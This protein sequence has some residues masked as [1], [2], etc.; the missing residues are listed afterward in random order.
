MEKIVAEHSLWYIPLCL[1]A[2]VLYAA[3]LYFRETKNEYP[4]QLRWGLAV[5]RA[6]AVSAIAFLLLNPLFRSVKKHSEN[7]VVL[8]L[9]DNSSSIVSGRD[10]TFYKAS[11]PEL[12]KEF[13]NQIGT[14]FDVESFT[15]SDELSSNIAEWDYSGQ[16]TNMGKALDAIY[17]RYAHRNVGA[18]V[19]LSDGINNRGVN[20]LYAGHEFNFPLYTVA[21]GDTALQTDL[22]VTRVDF[23]R[24]A[25]LENMFPVEISILGKKAEGKMAEVSIERNGRV[26][27]QTEI[28]FNSV[29]D[30][31][32]VQASLKASQTGM[33]KYTVRISSLDGEVSL[34]NNAYDFYIDVL[35]DKQKILLLANAP[36]PDVSAIK[37]AVGENINYTLDDFLIADFNGATDGYNLVILHGLPSAKNNITTIL[38]NLEQENMPC[39]FILTQRTYLPILNEQGT[40][41][42]FSGSNLLYNEAL[43]AV[44]KTFNLFGLSEK[45]EDAFDFLPPL[46]SPYGKIEMLPSATPLL[47]QQIG[48][49]RTEHPLWVFNQA[50]ER[51]NAVVLGPGLWKWRIKEYSMRGTHEAF[52]E[53]VNKT[54]QYLALRVDK[55]QFRVYGQTH[56]TE[57]DDIEF[58]AELYN[59]V[60]ELV[61]DPEVDITIEGS[62]GTKYPYSFS[63]TSNA[64]YLNAGNLSADTYTYAAHTEYGGDALTEKGEF[65]VSA[66]RLEQLSTEADHNLMLNL[67]GKYGG[68]MVYPDNLQTLAGVITD[69]EDIKTITYSQKRFSELLSLKWVLALILALLSVEWFVR[70]RAGGY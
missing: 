27:Y 9:Q 33:Q 29:K 24:I 52:N 60:F 47:L 28:S 34:V 25:Y 54:I 65:T 4:H 17:D 37:Q 8:V 12:V 31:K 50:L 26:L 21:L 7:P 69:R 67:A 20:P 32:T 68:E 49:V 3:I 53:I 44:N 13:T 16:E 55:S 15:F 58:Q 41:L 59:D 62:D 45:L 11:F 51:R 39:W 63:R 70:K 48:S 56:Y 1:I 35:E 18:L 46:I 40:G 14:T 38:K 64:Y 23:N 6:T 66:S 10:S 43:P 42:V 19:V 22:A 57:N 2:G 5:V 30:F 36:H 61:N